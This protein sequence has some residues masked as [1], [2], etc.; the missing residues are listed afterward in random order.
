[1]WYDS[2]WPSFRLC[3][4][5]SSSLLYLPGF[6]LE[7]TNLDAYRLLLFTGDHEPLYL[8]RVSNPGCP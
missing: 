8:Y 2:G 5:V 3:A 4:I 6:R 1:M 7:A